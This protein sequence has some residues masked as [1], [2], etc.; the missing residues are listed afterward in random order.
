MIT[1]HSKDNSLEILGISTLSERFG[2][3]Q[4]KRLQLESLKLPLLPKKDL[5]P[6]FNYR[7]IQGEAISSHKE[8]FVS[9][10]NIGGDLGARPSKNSLLSVSTKKRVTN[11]LGWKTLPLPPINRDVDICIIGN[12]N[13]E[14]N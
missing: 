14:T 6:V 4:P 13:K 2:S 1:G 3:F 10:L 12:S 7:K 5:N 9:A 8:M 11:Q